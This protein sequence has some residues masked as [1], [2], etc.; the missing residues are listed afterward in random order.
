MS[1]INN[2]LAFTGTGGLPLFAVVPLTVLCLLS[3]AEGYLTRLGTTMYVP[4]LVSLFSTNTI[5]NIYAGGTM[6]FL[7]YKFVKPH[8]SPWVPLIH[9]T[10]LA[11]G[12][13]VPASTVVASEVTMISAYGV[14]QLPS[15]VLI[16]GKAIS[17][18]RIPFIFLSLLLVVF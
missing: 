7:F 9:S 3:I 2:F 11:A 15:S 17:S 14:G 18:F 5:L 12:L 4:V 16:V 13:G 10:S 6:A 8:F 1:G